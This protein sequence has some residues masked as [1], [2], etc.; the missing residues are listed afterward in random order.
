[1]R[2]LEIGFFIRKIVNGRVVLEKQ[3]P[4]HRSSVTPSPES[5]TQGALVREAAPQS[6]QLEASPG[7]GVTARSE[8]GKPGT[9]GGPVGG[10]R[11]E[12]GFF[13]GTTTET[14]T[15]PTENP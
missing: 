5:G 15:S 11:I 2:R 7:G 12:V 6:S 4:S 14:T 8:H 9:E 10:T 13:V 3:F 1:V